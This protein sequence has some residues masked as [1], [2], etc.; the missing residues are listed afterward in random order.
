M[1]SVIFKSRI[2]P[3]SSDEYALNQF[4]PLLRLPHYD[5]RFDHLK[6]NMDYSNATESNIKAVVRFVQNKFLYSYLKTPDDS[7]VRLNYRWDRYVKYLAPKITDIN[8]R[9]EF[10][11]LSAHG[12]SAALGCV[13][14]LND[15][16]NKND[17]YS[18]GVKTL[19][20]TDDERVLLNIES[21][22]DV[23]LS[24]DK[25]IKLVW[26][27]K[28]ST[29]REPLDPAGYISYKVAFAV[30]W[31]I[32]QD[33]IPKVLYFVCCNTSGHFIREMPYTNGIHDMIMNMTSSPVN[34]NVDFSKCLMCPA[35]NTCPSSLR[36]KYGL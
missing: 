35:K 31:A 18:F 16:I 34:V 17:Q 29:H 15:L 26:L 30:R 24:T 1:K 9:R 23:I 5:G 32:N 22:I 20:R 33:I 19:T 4:C 8:K 27:S 3:V 25:H 13:Q 11:K 10:L 21:N 12:Y 36:K 28:P 7:Y 6:E 14:A 2:P